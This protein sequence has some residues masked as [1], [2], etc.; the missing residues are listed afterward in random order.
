MLKC[1]FIINFLKILNTTWES[2]KDKLSWQ[3]QSQLSVDQSEH[4]RSF[5][6]S[7]RNLILRCALHFNK[8]SQ[9]QLT[10]WKVKSDRN[11]LCWVS[12]LETV[13]IIFIHLNI[14][15]QTPLI[16]IQW[17][18]SLEISQ[19]RKCLEYVRIC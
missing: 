3:Y 10:A 4:V 11:I 17:M 12:L 14:S 8:C 6:I 18:I 2:F 19:K 1:G 7:L 15:L 9:S 13:I 16:M 5:L